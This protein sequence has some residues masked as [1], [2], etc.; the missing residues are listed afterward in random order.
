MNWLL[1]VSGE[2]NEI[3][4]KM[5]RELG[6]ETYYQLFR[7]SLLTSMMALVMRVEMHSV[8]V[9]SMLYDFILQFKWFKMAC[10]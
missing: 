4:Y 7:I 10:D 1:F 5:L 9:N 2:I 8:D 6:E 3:V